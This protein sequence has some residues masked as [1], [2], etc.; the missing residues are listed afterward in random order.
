ME[1]KKKPVLS[2]QLRPVTA[3]D[4]EFLY[5]LYCTTRNDELN[6]VNFPSE[7]REPFLQMQFAAQRTH[8]E[9][10]FPE[11]EHS[12]IIVDDKPVGRKYVNRAD[13][14]ILLVDIALLPE[15]CGFGIGTTELNNLCDES[16]LDQKPLRLHVEK[17]NPRAFNLYERLGFKVINDD[18]VYLFLEWRENQDAPVEQ[19]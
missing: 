1:T 3:G 11:A 12:I 6:A 4:F 8:Y 16:A 19:N 14:E 9:K 5:L 17:F 15:F 18:G 7:Q 10:Y 2:Y 13:N